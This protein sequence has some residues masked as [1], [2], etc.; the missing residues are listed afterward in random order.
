VPARKNIE[1]NEQSA[2]TTGW[3]LEGFGHQGQR[4]FVRLDKLPF[5]IGRQ[6]ECDL[7]LA[8]AEISRRHAEIF[9]HDGVLRIR[10]CGSTNG[11]FV[12]RQR[13]YEELA[14]HHGDIIHFGSLEFRIANKQTNM[15][16]H[17]GGGELTVS[18][19]AR[20]L[21]QGFVRCE[22][23][24]NEMLRQRAVDPH[25]QPL[26]QL[27]NT[28]TIGYELLGRCDF[29]GLPQGPLSLLQIAG[30]LHKEIELSELFREVGL[31]RARTLGKDYSLFLNTVPTEIRL[32]HLRPSLTSLREQTPDLQMVLEIHEAAVTNLAT[33]RGLRALLNDLDIKLAYDDFGAGQARLV[34]LIE[35][36]PD[37]LK[38][39]MV[40]VRGIHRQSPRSRQVLSTLVNMAR[41]LGIKTIAEGVEVEE[42]IVICRELGFDVAQGYYFGKPAPSF[43]IS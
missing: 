16:V 33:I 22:N 12:N 29:T 7:Q 41:D 26:V 20:E 42:E 18:M 14:L 31:E 34:E 11:T 9:D 37:W 40:L 25:F 6:K 8:F 32:S 4:W 19:S 10:E 28:Q 21:P 24:F 43:V 39:D 27:A 35:V 1:F 13:L 23:E 30:S 5:S 2:V 3:Y 17:S 38:F 15:M 36:P